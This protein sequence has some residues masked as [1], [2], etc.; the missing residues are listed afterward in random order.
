MISLNQDVRVAHNRI[1]YNAYKEAY[2]D[3]D[4][5]IH[6]GFIVA[7]NE[8]AL[9]INDM[10]FVLERLDVDDWVVNSEFDNIIIM[11]AYRLPFDHT[12]VNYPCII[13]FYGELDGGRM[14]FTHEV[15]NV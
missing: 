11:N 14:V 8:E 15:I 5:D 6:D 4:I 12:I 3:G 2:Y 13:R 7:Y 1:L 9:Y 10:K